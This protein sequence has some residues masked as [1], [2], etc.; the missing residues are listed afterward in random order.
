MIIEYINNIC[1]V[2]DDEI[3]IP[4]V[5]QEFKPDGVDGSEHIKTYVLKPSMLKQEISRGKTK[6][7]RKRVLV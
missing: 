3:S 6:T 5:A 7:Q 1:D 2:D 4:R